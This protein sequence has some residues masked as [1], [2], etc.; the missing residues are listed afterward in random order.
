MRYDVVMTVS[1]DVEYD[2]TNYV[3]SNVKGDMHK[4]GTN[5]EPTDLAIATDPHYVNNNTSLI[6]PKSLIDKDR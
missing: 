6:V 1:L 4:P 5:L 3:I 2:G